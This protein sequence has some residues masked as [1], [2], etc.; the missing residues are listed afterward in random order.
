MGLMWLRSLGRSCCGADVGQ[1]YGAGS[2]V[3]QMWVRSMEQELLWGTCELD[4]L[5]RRWCGA[6]LGQMYGA[7]ADVG[8]MLVR[9]IG[10]ELLWG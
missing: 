7:G 10:Q 2:A 5:V 8:L 1:S 6:D 9:S 3:W 4:P